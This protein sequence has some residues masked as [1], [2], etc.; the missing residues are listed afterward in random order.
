[1]NVQYIIIMQSDKSW[2]AIFVGITAG[3][4]FVRG[5]K[6]HHK[7]YSWWVVFDYANRAEEWLCGP[8]FRFILFVS[9][10]H[11]RLHAIR[12]AFCLQLFKIQTFI[13]AIYLTMY[14]ANY[15]RHSTLRLCICTHSNPFHRLMNELIDGLIDRWT[16][17]LMDWWIDRLMNRWTDESMDW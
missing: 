3:V 4:L 15:I 1:M 6:I 16:D 5:N 17:G 2:T 13:W 10:Q 8:I 7:M 11:Y 14:H 9:S 12:T